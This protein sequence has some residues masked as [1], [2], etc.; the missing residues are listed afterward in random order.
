MRLKTWMR[1]LHIWR[2]WGL[3]WRSRC[4]VVLSGRTRRKMRQLQSSPLSQSYVLLVKR[5]CIPETGTGELSKEGVDDQRTETKFETTL[6][7]AERFS[8]SLVK[9]LEQEIR[10]LESSHYMA[11]GME[12]FGKGLSADLDF[13]VVVYNSILSFF[14][15]RGNTVMALK[16]LDVMKDNEVEP[17]AETYAVLIRGFGESGDKAAAEAWFDSYRKSDLETDTAPYKAITRA[18][19]QCND[20]QQAIFIMSDIMPQDAVPFS[21]G[22]L[23]NFLD[24]LLMKGLH[25]EVLQWFKY[26]EDDASGQL[27]AVNGK[28]RDIAFSAA[29]A[30]R[31]LETAAS[32]FPGDIARNAFVGSICDFGLLALAQKSLKH[33]N[34]AFS[35]LSQLTERLNAPGLPDGAFLLAMIHALVHKRRQTRL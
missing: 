18:Y 29:T 21:S 35:K 5:R 19:V 20:T 9:E 27:P 23:V 1:Y 30:L 22:I 12:L 32:L 17:N 11:N 13:D 15:R 4:I 26:A 3:E 10:R 7:P 25:K 24:A 6:D 34:G 28:M 8:R 14:A 33:A 16:Y 2:V 31:E